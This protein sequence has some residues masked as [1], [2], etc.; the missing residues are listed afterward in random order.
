MENI[1]MPIDTSSEKK[2]QE[3]L[4]DAYQQSL[5][6]SE[7]LYEE[8]GNDLLDLDLP[9]TIPV[10]D[11]LHSIRNANIVNERLYLDESK[12]NVRYTYQ[13]KHEGNTRNKAT[14]YLNPNENRLSEI[15]TQ[16]PYGLVDKQATGIGATYSEMHSERNSIIVVPTRALGESKC[17][18]N[19][20]FLYVGTQRVSQRVT[21]DEKMKTYLNDSNIHFKKI[22][23]VADSLKRVIDIIKASSID[24]YREYFFMVDEI[25]TI[26][27]DNHYRP[28]LSNVI[29]YYRKFKL[30]RRALV[31]A[32]VKEFS[33][34]ELN[35]EPVTTIKRKEPLKRNITLLYTN[36]INKLLTEEIIRISTENPMD[37][38]LIA[39][40][41]ITDIQ[42]VID[43]LSEGLQDRCGILCSES[44]HG[45]GG[46]EQRFIAEIT[47][48]NRLSHDIVFMTCAYFAGLDISDECHLI[49]VSNVDYNYTILPVNRMTQIA[50]RCR[51]GLLSD[52]IIFNIR[53]EPIHYEEDYKN[54]LI[55][56]AQKIVDYFNQARVL[57]QDDNDLKIIFERIEPVI[58]E[59][60]Y[61]QV[62]SGDHIPLVRVNSLDNKFEISYFNID[63]LYEQMYS[64]SKLYSDKDSLYNALATNNNMVPLQEKL[65]DGGTQRE[66]QGVP[67]EIKMQRVQRCIDDL[68]AEINANEINVFSSSY[69]FR[70]I[71]ENKTR[72][73]RVLE[74]KLYYKRV[75]ELYKYMD[76]GILNQKLLSICTENVTSYNNLKNAVFFWA[77]EESHPFKKLIKNTFIIGQIYSNENIMEELSKILDNQLFGRSSINKT[78]AVRFLNSIIECERYNTRHNTYKINGHCSKLLTDLAVATP[79]AAISADEGVNQ[80]FRL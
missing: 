10:F 75:E 12:E 29:D 24:V 14:I 66:M 80:L 6:E 47:Q 49:T 39:Y 21:S 33:D 63:I 2:D 58:T 62:F 43:N 51:N 9:V 76:I 41:S 15:I 22:V 68:M 73:A 11:G 78:Q 56:K 79:L 60:A 61:E 19:P 4:E 1:L 28:Q 70:R 64:N 16:L 77:L 18:D 37:K 54:R 3:Y 55:H 30:Q 67:D 36:S 48:E 35:K 23:V 40:N 27:S 65:F 45:E 71:L 52:T 32:T 7:E 69:V 46:I 17:G 25:D 59:K 20:L 57:A 72:T 31:S 42:S 13:N 38:M 5:M 44:N 26:Q 53:R 50:G 74:K 8:A 34:P